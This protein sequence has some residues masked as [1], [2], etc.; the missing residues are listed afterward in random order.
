MQG[1]KNILLALNFIR[2][3]CKGSVIFY[4]DKKIVI[5]AKS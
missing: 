1:K 3:V 5:C 2:N 4:A